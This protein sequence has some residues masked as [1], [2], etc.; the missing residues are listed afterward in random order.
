LF[1]DALQPP[2]HMALSSGSQPSHSTGTYREKLGHTDVVV[3]VG[4]AILLEI[5]Q[6]TP[7]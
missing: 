3:N 7:E 1:A 6:D 5:T 4:E 2:Q